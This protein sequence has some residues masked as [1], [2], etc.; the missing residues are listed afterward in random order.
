[1]LLNV[2]PHILEIY[3]IKKQSEPI[4]FRDDLVPDR[5]SICAIVGLRVAFFI[6]LNKAVPEGSSALSCQCLVIRFDIH[7]SII[8][9]FH[10]RILNEKITKKTR[11]TQKL[12]RTR[13]RTPTKPSCCGQKIEGSC[14]IIHLRA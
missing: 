3:K 12:C 10:V 9:N 14:E 2:F 1:M 8:I 5:I 6:I 13:R 11:S 7:Q 4:L